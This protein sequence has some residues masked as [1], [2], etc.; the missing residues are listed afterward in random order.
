MDFQIGTEYKEKSTYCVFIK[1]KGVEE[2]KIY[3]SNRS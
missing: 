2:F 3:D 1:L